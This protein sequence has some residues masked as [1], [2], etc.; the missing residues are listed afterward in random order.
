MSSIEAA[1]GS[2]GRLEDLI[3]EYVRAEE[4]GKPLCRESLLSRHPEL[5]AELSEF[6]RHRDHIERLVAPLRQ[7]TSRVLNIRCPHCQNRIELVDTTASSSVNCPSCGSCFSLLGSANDNCPIGVSCI[8]QFQLIE[9]VG[10]GQFGSVWK[11]R[12][13]ALERVVAVKLPRQRV[14]TDADAEILLRDARVSAQ[15]RHPNI[16]SVHEVGKHEN[17]IY[18]VSDYIDGVTLREWM[19]A[20]PLR[21]REVASLMTTIANALHYAHESGVIHRDLK[22]SN[23]MIDR[24]GVPHI[25]DFGLAK[26]D[27]TE[28]TMTAEG[29]VLGTPAYMSPEQARGD[30]H[31]VDRRADVYAMGVMLYEM[32]TQ[33]LPFHGNKQ[34]LIV[35]VLHDEPR[36][37]RKINPDIPRD[38]ETICAKCLRKEPVHRYATAREL[39]DDLQRWL[40]GRPIIAR[41]VS[42]AEKILLWSKRRPA[43]ASLL[44]IVCVLLV[45]TGIVARNIQR[46]E[47]AHAAIHSLLTAPTDDLI[48]LLSAAKSNAQTLGPMLKSVNEK[49]LTEKEQLHLAVAQ[50]RFNGT[51]G[52]TLQRKLF[53]ATPRELLMIRS[54]LQAY[55]S[56]SSLAECTD[57]CWETVTDPTNSADKRLCAAGALATLDAANSRWGHVAPAVAALIVSQPLGEVSNWLAVFQPVSDK[58]DGTLDQIFKRSRSSTE[59]EVAA[60]ALAEYFAH[61][62]DRLLTFI[63]F[64]EAEHLNGFVAK[65]QL[66]DG[67]TKLLQ[68]RLDEFTHAQLTPI[69]NPARFHELPLHCIARIESNAGVVNDNFAIAPSLPFNEALLAVNEMRGSGYRPIR[70]RPFHAGGQTMVAVLW[71]RDGQDWLLETDLTESVVSTRLSQMHHEGLVPVDAAMY[72]RNGM[73]HHAV[74]WAAADSD[75][76]C[77]YAITVSHTAPERQLDFDNHRAKG[78]VPQTI[79]VALKGRDLVR[80][81]IWRQ[82]SPRSFRWQQSPT[83]QLLDNLSISDGMLLVDATV[84]PYRRHA[85]FGGVWQQDFRQ[86]YQIVTESTDSTADKF[87][88]MIASGYHPISINAATIQTPQPPTVTVVWHRPEVSSLE[89]TDRQQSHCN[90]V[91]ALLMMGDNQPAL[92]V[93]RQHSDPTLRS[94]LTHRIGRSSVDPSMIVELIDRNEI[95]PDARQALILCLH[96]YGQVLVAYRDSLATRLKQLYVDDPDAG[97][98]GAASLLLR[99]WRIPVDPIPPVEQP[100]PGTE[101]AWYVDKAQ[102]TMVVAKLPKEMPIADIQSYEVKAPGRVFAI[103]AHEVTVGQFRAFRPDA[104]FGSASADHPACKISWFDAVAYCQYLNELNGLLDPS[105]WCYLP[106]ADGKF[107]HGM[108][109]PA[110]YTSRLGY[111]LVSTEEFRYAGCAMAATNFFFGNDPEMLSQYAWHAGNTSQ[112]MPVGTR[113]PNVFGLFDVHGNAMEWCYGPNDSLAADSLYVDES[114]RRTVSGGSINDLPVQLGQYLV[115]HGEPATPAQWPQGFRVARTI[116]PAEADRVVVD[117]ATEFWQAGQCMGRQGKWP[118][119][120]D[121]LERAMRCMSPDD[122]RYVQCAAQLFAIRFYLNDHERARQL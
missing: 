41:P 116:V 108:R 1:D 79:H 120:I 45:F 101:K 75:S 73:P 118:E 70:F 62:P 10:V 92:K 49:H 34:M 15:L 76:A 37:P 4:S 21:A 33:Q 67:G 102:H 6:F 58:L 68:R 63:E 93:L 81:Q 95:P 56:A 71:T 36:A 11:A 100:L 51:D 46:R 114:Q 72:L 42:H 22:P 112:L 52:R 16:V 117:E 83:P 25:V 18:I 23:V 48:T 44:A 30:S 32:L 94:V 91:T 31:R 86:A 103:S 27:A 61:D 26:R 105:N 60:M 106:N 89:Q 39:A 29:Q 87:A 90:L 122:P 96:N 88:T 43:V 119:A 115:Q 7:A 78:F 53:S 98:H 8:G 107:A 74:I 111:R 77:E 104:D 82:P 20:K 47:R 9:Q 57:L 40:D 66:I 59:R 54:V 55:A 14:V 64:A 13:L 28:I 80:T 84:F 2:A 85:M 113:L 110:D 65:M 109:I 99:D 17:A 12:D 69:A 121:S 50:L 19:A 38:L 5:A 97:V 35:Q 24:R 3:A